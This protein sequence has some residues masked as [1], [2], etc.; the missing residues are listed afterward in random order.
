MTDLWRKALSKSFSATDGDNCILT[1]AEFGGA[2]YVGTGRCDTVKSANI[3]RLIQNGCKKWENVTPPWSSTTGGYQ[4]AMTV[5]NNHL[6][7]GTDQGEVFRTDD[8]ENWNNVTGNLPP[9]GGISAMSEFNGELYITSYYAEIWQTSDGTKWQQVFGK[10]HDICSLEVFKGHL[11]AG[12]GRDNDNGIELWRTND[13]KNWEKFHKVPQFVGHVHALKAFKGYLYVGRY[14]GKGLYRTDGSLPPSPSHWEE[15]P[16]IVQGGDIFRLAEHNGKLFLGVSFLVSAPSQVPLLYC[17]MNGTQWSP[18]PGSPTGGP[19]TSSIVSLLSLAERLYV[20]TEN[21]STSGSVLLWEL[22]PEVVPDRFEP[23]DTIAKA[24]PIKLELTKTQ[25]ATE[26]TN[27]TLHKN[28]VDF[29]EIEYQSALGEEGAGASYVKWLLTYPL[30][31]EYFPGYL[32]IHAQEEYCLPLN[33]EIYDSKGNLLKKLDTAD[34][35]R[36]TCPTQV[37]NDRKLFLAIRNPNGQ[38]PVR[39]KLSVLFSNSFTRFG[40]MKLRYRFWEYLPPPYPPPPFLKLIDPATK[41]YDLGQFVADSER[42]L[43]QFIEYRDEIDKA[44]LEHGLGQIAHRAGQYD[45][46]ERFYKQSLTTFQKLETTARE[47]EVLRNLGELYSVRGRVEEALESFEKA[48][49]L[50]EKLKDFVG[51]AND[52]ISLGRHYLARREASNSLAA[53]EEGWD[54]LVGSPDRSGR[55]LNLLYQSEAFLILNWQEAAVACLT[56]AED[57]LSGIEDSILHEEVGQRIEL[58]KARLGEQEFL[59]LKERIAG[60]AE[61][62]WHRAISRITKNSSLDKQ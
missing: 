23:N 58:V 37:F 18:V 15:M 3:C 56:L 42:L 50:H 10:G 5:F 20:G 7:V 45:D 36:F 6:Y 19:T 51:L 24:T 1:L 61:I 30:Y 62:S 47:A 28:D 48:S 27:L 9:D 40:V 13:G 12:V 60:E 21:R 44:D 52:R 46:A 31:A 4:M 54:L 32:S 55:I 17:S 25:S 16:L 22:G 34:A 29:F 35:V 53:L 57:L 49:Q 39:Y 8:G 59:E 11:Y 26:L 2:L 33:L 43:S 41:Y 14:H 38:P